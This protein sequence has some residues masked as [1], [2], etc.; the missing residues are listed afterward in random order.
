MTLEVLSNWSHFW[1]ECLDEV[2]L[3][4]PRQ[5]MKDNYLSE[6]YKLRRVSRWGQTRWPLRT[7]HSLMNNFSDSLRRNTS[8]KEKREVSQYFPGTS[9]YTTSRAQG[10]PLDKV[11]QMIWYIP[12]LPFG[13]IRFCVDFEYF[14]KPPADT[15][16]II[17]IH[18]WSGGWASP[19]V[20]SSTRLDIQ[21][22]IFQ[23]KSELIQLQG[24]SCRFW[25][26]EENSDQDS[27]VYMCCVDH[28]ENVW[29]CK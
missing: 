27:S 12:D 26:Y 19:S 13:F 3:L 10:Y 21:E 15:L 6:R 11:S 14:V 5:V 23:T 16:Q 1:V 9:F 2:P 28:A 22:I 18:E 24:C 29:R 20:E 7:L 8:I 17:C 25:S 4:T